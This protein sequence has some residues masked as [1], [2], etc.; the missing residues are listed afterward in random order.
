M[1][2]E[3]EFKYWVLNHP[4]VI[5]LKKAIICISLILVMIGGASAIWLNTAT[6]F[7]KVGSQFSNPIHVVPMPTTISQNTSPGFSVQFGQ[8]FSMTPMYLGTRPQAPAASSAVLG[9]SS[10][11]PMAPAGTDFGGNWERNVQLAQSTSSFRVPMNNN[12]SSM[13]NPWLVFEIG[14]APRLS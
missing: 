10:G 3:R 1:S 5:H 12:W 14:Q 4:P 13:D 6:S 2:T 7:D 11:I 9:G 8:S